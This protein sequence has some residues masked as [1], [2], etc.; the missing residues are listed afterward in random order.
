MKKITKRL[1]CILLALTLF[2]GCSTEQTTNNKFTPGEYVV[3]GQGYAPMSVT[4]TFDENSITDIQID[5]TETAGIGLEAVPVAVDKIITEQALGWDVVTGATE[6]NT[7]IIEAVTQAMKDA[8]ATQETIDEYISNVGSVAEQKEDETLTA[9]VVII[10]A[11]GA[12]MSAAVTAHQEGKS[13]IVIEKTAQMGGNTTLAGGALNAVDEG[14]ETALANNDS[15][16]LH[17]TQTFEGGD[18]QGNPELVNILVSEAWDGVE[19]LQSLGMEFKEG[20]FTVT[21]GLWQR[22]HAPVEPKGSGFFKTYQEYMDENEGITMLYNTEAYELVVVDGVVTGVVATGETG[23]TITV[24]ANNGIVLATGG[25]G[26]SIELREEYTTESEKWPLLDASIPST[27]TTSIT[28]DGIIMAEAIG[29]NL[30]QM[31]NIQLLPLG[32]PETGSLSGNIEHGV[33]SRIFVNLDGN[34][35]VDEGGRRDDMTLGLLAQEEKTMYIVMD[36]DSYPSGDTLNNFGESIDSLVEQGRAYKADT[37]EE[38]AEMINVPVENLVST[39]EEY[40]KYC[41]GGEL[42]G[43]TDEFGRTLFTDTEQVHDG[44]NDGPFYAAERVPTVHH[45]MGGVEIN[46]NTEVINTEGNVILGLYA[47]GEVTGG[48]HGANRLGGNAL[49]DTVVFGRIAGEQAAAFER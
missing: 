46:T 15:V 44:I 2:V 16:E 27:N 9:D 14:S 6:T 1:L 36:S 32:D 8:G 43:E 42:E 12:G 5:H 39:V 10:G 29:A 25:F 22:A 28:G 30:V 20:T 7:G 41:L 3:E 11:G 26:Q 33:E 47:A 24:N 37:L 48:I 17:Y 38:L 23:N 45:T 49:T 4:V 21:G 31:D 13:V 40:N 18:E 35:F 19:W 34:R